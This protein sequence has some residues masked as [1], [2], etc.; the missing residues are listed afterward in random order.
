M[1]VK[2]WYSSGSALRSTSAEEVNW[3]VTSRREILSWK[4]WVPSSLQAHAYAEALMRVTHGGFLL[5]TS[6]K[7]SEVSGLII[8]GLDR[9]ADDRTV[10]TGGDVLASG[11]DSWRK[12][13]RPN[14]QSIVGLKWVSQWYP[15]TI[16]QLWSNRVTK[17]VRFWISPVGNRIGPS[18]DWVMIEFEV[19][20]INHNLI[21]GMPHVRRWWIFMEVESMNQ[22]EDPESTRDARETLGKVSEDSDSIRESGFE[23][24]DVLTVTSD[25][26]AWLGLKAMA[27]AWLFMALAFKILRPGQSHQWRLASARLWPKPWLKYKK[28]KYNTNLTF[29]HLILSLHCLQGSDHPTLPLLHCH[30]ASHQLPL[31]I[32]TPQVYP[33][34]GM[35]VLLHEK[36]DHGG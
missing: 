32:P 28:Y 12:K 33:Q 3:P 21:G 31:Q 10:S 25:V 35:T 30:Q 7:G 14:T 18:N 5:F 20:S 6:G 2:L 8:S 4:H 23:R 26:P 22:L 24:A 34:P 15:S 36:V 13:M 17:N 11:C 27:L 1:F 29:N 16:M 19:L 9:G